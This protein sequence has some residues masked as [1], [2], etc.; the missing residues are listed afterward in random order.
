MLR[1]RHV[2][3]AICHHD[4]GTSR[5]GAPGGLSVDPVTNPVQNALKKAPLR[6]HLRVQ[7]SYLQV[8]VVAVA[9]A[10]QVQV[11]QGQLLFWKTDNISQH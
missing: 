6:A 2:A 11:E 5:E 9:Q 10:E 4:V 7:Q 3:I 8:G 1:C